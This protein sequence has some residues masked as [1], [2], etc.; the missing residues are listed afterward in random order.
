[1]FSY[2]N[3]AWGIACEVEALPY[4]SWDYPG[5]RAGFGG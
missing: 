3:K 4:A 1:M 2:A 5:L